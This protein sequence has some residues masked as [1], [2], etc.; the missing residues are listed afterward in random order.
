M[1]SLDSPI[2]NKSPI[3]NAIRGFP[4]RSRAPLGNFLLYQENN[5][6]VPPKI[7]LIESGQ[8]VVTVAPS[9][10]NSP[11]PISESTCPMR[12]EAWVFRA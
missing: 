6:F 11:I 12:Q 7:E 10:R 2:L 8:S 1:D 5:G 9:A 3:F 4:V